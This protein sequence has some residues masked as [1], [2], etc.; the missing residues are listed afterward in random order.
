MSK[1]LPP[2]GMRDFNPTQTRRRELIFSV[3]KEVFEKYGYQQI[4][5][6]AMEHLS[7]L[8]GKYGDEGERLMYKVLNSGDYLAG[9]EG[10]WDSRSLTPKICDKAL[11]YDLTVPFARYV[12]N[13]RNELP[14]PFKRYQIQPVWRADRPQKGRYREFYQC[15][16]DAVGSRSLQ[17]EAEF[18]LIYDEAL[19]RLGF[20]DFTIHLNH[21]KILT[22]MA[23]KIGAEARFRDVCAALDK[24][25]KVGVEGVERELRERGVVEYQRLRPILRGMDVQEFKAWSEGEENVAEGLRQLDEIFS[26]LA[27]VPPVRAKVKFNPT[28]ARGLDY[29]TGAIMEVTI[30]GGGT[31]SVGGG[32]RYDDLT[33]AF[34]WK[35]LPGV[36]ISFGVDRIYDAMETLGL[37]ERR[38]LVVSPLMFVN[39]GGEYGKRSFLLAAECRNAGLAAEVYPDP[40]HKLA[41]QFAYADKRGVKKVAVLGPDDWSVGKIQIKDMTTG[42]Q[43]AVEIKNLIPKM[44]QLMHIVPN[45]VS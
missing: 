19:S 34:G 28:L 14:L 1:Y 33:G 16:A 44:R 7:V 10:P 20:L 45:S 26:F 11:R 39:F 35:D 36:G 8:T 13:H 27:V 5:T 30:D 12:V 21:R 31:G 22:G 9:V 2:S 18:V 6:P 24:L 23:R 38:D 25:D 3:V 4:Q 42:L 40:S 37:F 32:G 41:K 43:D 29:Y 17:F 15:D